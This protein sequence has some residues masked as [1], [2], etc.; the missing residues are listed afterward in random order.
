VD[1]LPKHV[2]DQFTD[3]DIIDLNAYVDNCRCLCQTHY[4]V[5]DGLLN[6]HGQ[7]IFDRALVRGDLILSGNAD[8]QRLPDLLAVTG[9]IHLSDCPNLKIMPTRMYA[10]KSIHLDRTAVRDLPTTMVA[11][12]GIHMNDC[13]NVLEIP[14]GIRAD[15]LY[16][17]GCTKLES[18]ASGLEYHYL[19]LSGTPI[20]SL[21]SKLTIKNELK[22]RNCTSL[23]LIEEGATVAKFIDVRGCDML[24]TLPQS[25]QPHVAITDGMMVANDWVV[26]PEMSPEEANMCLGFK[27]IEGFP[28]RHF[29]NL[30]HMQD[31]ILSVERG[32]KGFRKGR[33]VGL[34][35]SDRVRHG[36]EE[37]L[38]QLVRRLND[39]E[40]LL[41]TG[42][43]QVKRLT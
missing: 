21:P 1:S 18:I 40:T 6:V 7:P 34:L 12:Q 36:G 11:D 14:E 38:R 31:P 15:C 33:A 13:P 16:A 37:F 28:H 39:R 42:P 22:L 35:K 26:V 29:K 20:R 25:I 8:I 4:I 30:D 23:A 32:G 9:S 3:D 27:G 43:V 24:F 17:A 19:D 5:K 2:T 41:L 10:G